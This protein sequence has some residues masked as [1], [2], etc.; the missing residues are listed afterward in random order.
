MYSPNII[1]VI[2]SRRMRWAEH[3]AL[4]GERRGVYR[5]LVGKPEGKNHLEDPGVD[6]RAILIC[7]LRNSDVRVWNGSSW[8]RIV[9]G[10]GHL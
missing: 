6:G 3:V 1:R 10:G 5:V 2:K 7:I 4:M 9:T 8:L